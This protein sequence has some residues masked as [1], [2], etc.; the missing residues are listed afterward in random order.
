MSYVKNEVE[1]EMLRAIQSRPRMLEKLACCSFTAEKD[2]AYDILDQELSSV[3]RNVELPY[4]T[5]GF[6][7]NFNELKSVVCMFDSHNHFWSQVFDILKLSKL[8]YLI[9]HVLVWEA[10]NFSVLLEDGS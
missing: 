3:I 2:A 6:H 4:I 5:F 9:L 1:G 7:S 10:R 8:L